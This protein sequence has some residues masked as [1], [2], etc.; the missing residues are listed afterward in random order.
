MSEA[1]LTVKGIY[2]NLARIGAFINDFVRQAGFDD[3]FRYALEM[4]VD[5]ACS[6][7]IEHGYAGEGKGDIALTI[8]HLQDGQAGIKVTIQ[9]QGDPFNPDDIPPPNTQAPLEERQAGGLGL[10]LIRQLM[11]EV[12]FDF[13]GGERG[14]TNTLVIIK[15]LS[16]T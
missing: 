3:R 11:D 13:A 1:T 7:I 10:F 4:A 2:S 16:I 15:R 14:D 9:D 6:N 8:N 5:E 12:Y